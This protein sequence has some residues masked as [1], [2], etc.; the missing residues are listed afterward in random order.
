VDV[1]DAAA[2]EEFL[3]GA[4]GFAAG[5]RDDDGSMW[6]V[7]EA[8]GLTSVIERVTDRT[9]PRGTWTLAGGTIHHFAFNT[10]DEERQYALKARLEGMGYT[11]VS[12]QKDRMYF[13]SMYMRSPGGAL[14][15]LAWTVPE[16]WAKDEP[17]D[18]IGQS[19]VFPPWFADRQA[20]MEAGLEP[21]RF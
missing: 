20:E 11:D 17:A 19:L 15:E 14:F 3:D 1:T 8:N 13:K 7:P 6:V 5:G 4:M 9:S 21:A 18:Q 12:E 10:I 2:M 16:G